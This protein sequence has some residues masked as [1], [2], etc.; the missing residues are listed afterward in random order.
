MKK[1]TS[2]II[3]LAGLVAFNACKDDIIDNS[4]DPSEGKNVFLDVYHYWNGNLLSKDSIY[5]IPGG[6]VKITNVKVL[7]SNFV[8]INDGDSVD[9]GKYFGM[10]TLNNNIVPLG[11]IEPMSY[12]GDMYISAGL[13]SLHSALPPVS[14]PV[15]SPMAEGS[16][17]RGGLDGYNFLEITGYFKDGADTSN[18]APSEPFKWVLGTKS[19]N[20]T[21]QR[22][23]NFVLANAKEAHFA[24]NID[25]RLLMIYNPAQV[26]MINCDP[27]DADDFAKA[28]DLFNAFNDDAF[29]LDQ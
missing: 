18:S 11:N 28:T 10:S 24:A 26:P 6:K 5:E 9:A 20:S 27:T 25:V 2:L 13:D 1:L 22:P 4:V 16:T 23:A 14:Q 7:Y 15:G 8:L 19:F 3:L 12:S 29:T 17:Y 21:F